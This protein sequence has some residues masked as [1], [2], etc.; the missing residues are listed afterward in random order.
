M[1]KRRTFG[2]YQPV[3][4]FYTPGVNSPA[5]RWIFGYGSLIWRPGFQYEARVLGTVAGWTRRFWQGSTDHRGRPGTPGRVVTLVPAPS[6]PCFCACYRVH[7]S[8]WDAIMGRLDYRE[9]NGYDRV[10]VVVTQSGGGAPVRATTY[11]ATPSNPHYL[12]GA[13]PEVIAHTIAVAGGPSGTNL[14]YFL[15]LRSALDQEG[16]H[17]AHLEALHEAL[18]RAGSVT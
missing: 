14:D 2:L 7:A 18:A 11:V 1:A 12:G 15:R 8:V 9:K 5:S 17:E 10:D 6:Q 4:L 3:E 13:A 16:V